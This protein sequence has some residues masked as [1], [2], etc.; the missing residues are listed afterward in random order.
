MHNVQDNTGNERFLLEGINQLIQWVT[1]I[2][3]FNKQSFN[4]KH[5]ALLEKRNQKTE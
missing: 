2:A 1:G 3:V 5:N 4:N